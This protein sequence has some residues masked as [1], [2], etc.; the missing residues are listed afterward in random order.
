M[1]SVK[2]EHF[3]FIVIM[4]FHLQCEYKHKTTEI[5]HCPIIY[6]LHMYFI[7]DLEECVNDEAPCYEWVFWK[8]GIQCSW[9]YFP[10]LINVLLLL[11]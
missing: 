4:W 7:L 2:A 3:D 10:S 1:M 8:H 5:C 6:G 9:N 11:F